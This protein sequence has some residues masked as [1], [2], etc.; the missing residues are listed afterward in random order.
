MPAISAS[1]CERRSS[2]ASPTACTG[3]RK[4]SVR[5]AGSNRKSI[6]SC[7]S[8]ISLSG[9]LSRAATMVRSSA[10]NSLRISA[11][12]SSS[13]MM[14]STA[15]RMIAPQSRSMRSLS[16][17]GELLVRHAR[18]FEERAQRAAMRP[19]G[20]ARR[21]GG[22]GRGLRGTKVSSGGASRGIVCTRRRLVAAEER[23]FV[24]QPLG[25]SSL[26]PACRGSGSSS[27]PAS[28]GR[29]TAAAPSPPARRL[30]A[31][32]RLGQ[33]DLHLVL[34]RPRTSR[35]NAAS[36]RVPGP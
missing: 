19:R 25:G 4:P 20:R 12:A 7:G 3:S 33:H 11:R 35:P 1:S 23:R 16:A 2:Q 26:G 13:I 32:G 18:A 28:A 34:A 27:A 15:A 21:C 5:S 29:S 14:P 30:G 22:A 9:L 10:S 6:A 24:E 31:T 8:D 17:G 36:R